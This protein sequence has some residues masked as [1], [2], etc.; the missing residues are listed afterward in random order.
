MVSLHL[1]SISINVAY[2]I[3]QADTQS[4]L[5]D[6]FD[7]PINTSRNNGI[8]GTPTNGFHDS[9]VEMAPLTHSS[10]VSDSLFMDT[11]STP[12]LGGREYYDEL[13]PRTYDE[14]RNSLQRNATVELI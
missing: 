14:K 2:G 7:R 5:P 9:T 1:F 12:A 3:N 6:T 13:S 10:I 8:N 11:M 4:K